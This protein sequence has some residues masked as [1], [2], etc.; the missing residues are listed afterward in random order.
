MKE[1]VFVGMSGGVDSS[2]AAALL[3]EQGYEVIGFTLDLWDGKQSG[4]TEAVRDG[5]K[6]AQQLGIEHYVLEYKELFRREVVDYFLKEYAAARTPNPCVMCNK[7]IK[8]GEVFRT[9]EQLGVAYV[10]TGHYVRLIQDAETGRYMLKMPSDRHKDQTYMLYH[11]SQQQLAKIKMPLGDYTKDEVRAIAKERGLFVADKADSQDICFLEGCTLAD[12][13]EKYDP[14]QLKQG[15]V[16]DVNGN[17]LGTH[18]GISRYTL[19]QRRGLGIA[20]DAKLYVKALEAD[21][22]RVVLSDETALFATQLIAEEVSFQWIEPPTM[23]LAVQAKIRYA[24][25][26]SAATVEMLSNGTARVTFEQPQRAITPGQAVVF[27]QGDI[28]M[29]GGTIRCAV[30]N[31]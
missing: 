21:T 14:A 30:Q 11:L 18:C 27:Y 10:A 17:V 26:P 8:F 2:V 15:Q 9:A 12:F 1:K 19:G 23:P 29:G 20:S 3:Q 6:V 24:S 28:V 22:N 4:E 16:V 25:R 13:I 31:Q 7:K 5:K